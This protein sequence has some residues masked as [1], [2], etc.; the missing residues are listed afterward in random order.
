VR[1]FGFAEIRRQ[2][3]GKNAYQLMRYSYISLYD[4]QYYGLTRAKVTLA[5]NIKNRYFV[6]RRSI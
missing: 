6:G 4:C 3:M 2:L 5:E 1:Y